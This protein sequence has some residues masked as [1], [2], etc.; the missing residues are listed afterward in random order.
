MTNRSINL[1]SQTK[2]KIVNKNSEPF[3]IIDEE[4]KNYSIDE[5]LNKVIVGD[6]L[7]VM[8]KMPAES[9][10]CVFVDPPYFLQLPPKKLLRWTGS[11]VNGVNDQR[12]IFKDFYDYDNFT[13]NYLIEIKSLMKSTATIWI[14]GTCY[15]IHFICVNEHAFFIFIC[16]IFLY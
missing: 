2:Q 8:K 9:L 1:N 5:I 7:K 4:Q 14:M 3:I 13:K 10:D 15:N 11:V 16:F 6:C 12:D